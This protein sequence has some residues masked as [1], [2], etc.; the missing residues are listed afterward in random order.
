MILCA[1]GSLHIIGSAA[2]LALGC[3]CV[4]FPGR[5]NNKG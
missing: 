2:G 3:S 4:S 1:G 5:Q